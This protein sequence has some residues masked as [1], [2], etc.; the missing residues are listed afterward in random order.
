MEEEFKELVTLL[1]KKLQPEA[2]SSFNIKGAAIV[3][4]MTVIFGFLFVGWAV[5]TADIGRLQENLRNNTEI[6]REF[7]INQEK[8]MNIIVEIRL[9]QQRRQ[10]K[11]N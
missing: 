2:E 5:N 7:K 1:E 9:D 6:V 3:A 4:L 8:M 11:E 10:A